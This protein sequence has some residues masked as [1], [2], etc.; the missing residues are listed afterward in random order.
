MRPI[1]CKPN[2]IFSERNYRLM[3]CLHA[4][5]DALFTSARKA[6]YWAQPFLFDLRTCQKAL[7][8]GLLEEIGTSKLELLSWN[9]Q[10]A[11]FL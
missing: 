11:G 5:F 7:K 9:F 2:Q 8:T 10:E 4:V 3:V 6:A 1:E